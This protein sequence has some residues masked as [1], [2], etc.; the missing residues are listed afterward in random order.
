MEATVALR[1]N[2]IYLLTRTKIYVY[3]IFLYSPNLKKKRIIR[4]TV[5]KYFRLLAVILAFIAG[6]TEACATERRTVR[7]VAVGGVHD[8][9]RV[10]CSVPHA[11]RVLVDFVHCRHLQQH[12]VRLS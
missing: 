9:G 7:P 10:V 12:R 1:V 3:Y 6:A 4:K 2:Q 11:L 5:N 8:V